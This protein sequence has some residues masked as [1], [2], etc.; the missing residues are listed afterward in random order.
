MSKDLHPF[1]LLLLLCRS[2]IT[3]FRANCLADIFIWPQSVFVK[4][5]WKT[6][7]VA[8]SWGQQ[9]PKPDSKQKLAC[10]LLSSD[11]LQHWCLWNRKKNYLFIWGLKHNF[12]MTKNV[13]ITNSFSL[14]ISQSGQNSTMRTEWILNMFIDKFP[15]CSVITSRF[16]LNLVHLAKE[17]KHLALLPFFCAAELLVCAPPQCSVTCGEGMERRLVTCRNGD[18]CS[19]EKPEAVRPCR[20][21][22]CHGE[23]KKWILQNLPEWKSADPQ[24]V[25]WHGQTEQPVPF[26]NSPACFGSSELWRSV[27]VGFQAVHT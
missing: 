20:L 1:L 23:H 10:Y 4:R 22:P 24:E 13:L 27:L 16:L 19:G 9:Q 8:G 6:S 25:N 12:F 5:K 14:F 18:Q 17:A 2:W 7:L 3:S 26:T 15:V 11:D 21:G